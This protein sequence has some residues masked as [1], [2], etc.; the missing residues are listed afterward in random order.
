MRHGIVV[1]TTLF[2]TE[3]RLVLRTIGE[4]LGIPYSD[5]WQRYWELTHHAV[6]GNFDPYSKPRA[7]IERAVTPRRPVDLEPEA[8]DVANRHLPSQEVHARLEARARSM[9]G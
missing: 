2:Q 7:G 1:S 5:D 4:T 3:P 8:L 6:G 9:I